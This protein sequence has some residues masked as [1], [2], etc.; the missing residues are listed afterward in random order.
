MALKLGAP[1]VVAQASPDVKGWGPYQ[2]PR[3][4]RLADGSIHVA[5]HVEADSAKAYGLAMGHA[6]SR[7]EGQSWAA[8]ADLPSPGGILLPNGERLLADS[9]KSLPVDGLALPKPL[10]S[11]HASY[12][13]YDYYPPD[14]IP[15]G[16]PRAWPFLRWT[17]AHGWRQE[18][19]AVTFKRGSDVRFVTE[20]VLVC[21]FFEQDRI[22]LAPDGTLLATLYCVP[23]FARRHRVVRP[24]LTV[25]LSSADGGRTW[26]EVGAIPYVGDPDADPFFDARDGFSEPEF[27]LMPDGSILAFLRT[28]DGNGN[29]PMYAARSRDRGAT[30]SRPRLFDDRGVWPQLLTLG[31]G[32]TLAAYG[33]PGLFVRATRDQGGDLAGDPTDHANWSPRVTVREP[34]S[35]EA[36]NTCSY[37]DLLPL[38]PRRALLI[39]SDF[40]FPNA[41]G[42]PCKTMIA[43]TI[44]VPD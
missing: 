20:N 42:T 41:N 12:V 3:V 18:H 25:L 31:S 5:Y 22:R 38:G 2:F 17:Q 13:D 29:G 23:D 7:D 27:N 32:V 6:I 39:Y 44:D 11:I 19:A 1:V 8:V 26:Q 33:R 14:A 16:Q 37:S 21:P 40:L 35:M 4:E 43:R 28:S 15:P 9:S 10:A 34:S 24:F 30:W 36:P